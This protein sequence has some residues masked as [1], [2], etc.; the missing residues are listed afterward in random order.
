M[1]DSE[2]D[3]RQVADEALRTVHSYLDSLQ[4]HE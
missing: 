2:T 4:I 3:Y 1:T